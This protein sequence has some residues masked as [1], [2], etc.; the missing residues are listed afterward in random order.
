MQI[1]PIT[2]VCIII[3]VGCSVIKRCVDTMSQSKKYC[4][5]VKP[6]SRDH[7]AL[8]FLTHGQ[9]RNKRSLRGVKWRRVES[10]F[11]MEYQNRFI[12][13]DWPAW[14]VFE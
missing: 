10:P 2:R 9:L 6:D 14:I 11:S 4:I 8:H 3:G 12:R 13:N 5:E 1:Y 7:D